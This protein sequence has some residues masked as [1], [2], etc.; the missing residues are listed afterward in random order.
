M[1][2]PSDFHFAQCVHIG[3]CVFSVNDAKY[4][5]GHHSCLG[6][7]AMCPCCQKTSEHTSLRK[8]IPTTMHNKHKGTAPCWVVS[9]S[10][11]EV[12]LVEARGVDPYW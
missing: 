5:C 9:F 4:C 2:S 6:R 1:Y 11:L 10:P 3:F 7:P 8:E 12:Q